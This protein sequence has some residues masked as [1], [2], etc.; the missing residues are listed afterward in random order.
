MGKKKGHQRVEESVSKML[1]R[2]RKDSVSPDWCG[3]ANICVLMLGIWALKRRS[4][5][6][7]AGLKKQTLQRK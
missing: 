6:T 4:R 3:K 2:S 1:T 7:G 5:N